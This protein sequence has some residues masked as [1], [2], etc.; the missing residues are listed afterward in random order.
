VSGQR[1][2][3]KPACLLGHVRSNPPA[4]KI[5][6]IAKFLIATTLQLESPVTHTKQTTGAFLIATNRPLLRLRTQPPLR[7]RSPKRPRSRVKFS[8]HRAPRLAD[9]PSILDV[10]PGCLNSRDYCFATGRQVNF[11]APAC[12]CNRTAPGHRRTHSQASKRSED[13]Q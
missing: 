4:E 9:P 8:S 11:E 1:A 5:P 10:D 7:S 3:P 6:Q 13:K 12:Q 2:N